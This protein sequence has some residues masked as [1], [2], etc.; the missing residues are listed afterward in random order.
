MSIQQGNDL[1][2]P[3][4]SQGL[5]IWCLKATGNKREAN[6]SKINSLGMLHSHAG[7]TSDWESSHGGESSYGKTNSSPILSVKATSMV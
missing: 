5:K 7:V 4:T 2:V 6:N 1:A 3:A